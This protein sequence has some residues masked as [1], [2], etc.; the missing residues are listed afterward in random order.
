MPAKHRDS[1]IGLSSDGFHPPKA[2][3]ENIR[4]MKEKLCFSSCQTFCFSPLPASPLHAII[5]SPPFPAAAAAA[6]SQRC[7][8]PRN[9]SRRH[10]RTSL[11]SAGLQPQLQQ[12]GA[13]L[14][15]RFSLWLST[16]WDTGQILL[17]VLAMG[18]LVLFSSDICFQFFW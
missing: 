4:G 18:D 2:I 3:P 12:S 1:G 11:T 10:C 17:S 14:K 9:L 16:A 13:L 5:S 7:Q 8:A 15:P 6:V